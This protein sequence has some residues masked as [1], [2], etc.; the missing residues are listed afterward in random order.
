MKTPQRI[1]VP[2]THGHSGAA[3]LRHAGEVAASRQAELLVVSVVDTRSGFEPDGPA[4]SLPGERAAR[5]APAEQKRLESEL[6]R[7]GLGRAT[8]TV[9]WGEPRAALSALIARWQ[10]DTIVCDGRT[11]RM[12]PARMA[13]AGPTLMTIGSNPVA[14]LT[15]FFFPHA[16]GHA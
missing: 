3:L 12:L 7:H 8:A 10:P 11:R 14:R 13:P 15:G 6:V 5:L 16:Q 4:A 9:I 1:L 2:F